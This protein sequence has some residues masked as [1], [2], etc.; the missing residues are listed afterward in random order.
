MSVKNF[1][2]KDVDGNHWPDAAL[3]SS[4]YYAICFGSWL[5]SENDSLVNVTWSLPDG[6]TGEDSFEDED[7]AFI[8]LTPT[9]RGS[10]TIV[11]NLTSSESG[12]QQIKTVPMVLKVY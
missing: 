12:K 4:L 2:Y 11:C 1:L 5:T 8:K 9:K 10:F 6:V 3:G 7:E